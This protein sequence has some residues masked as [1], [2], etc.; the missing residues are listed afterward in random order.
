M[1]LAPTREQSLIFSLFSGMLCDLVRWGS[2]TVYKGQKE[3]TIEYFAVKSIDKSLRSK[4]LTKVS[5]LLPCVNHGSDDRASRSSVS[6][7]VGCLNFAPGL[8]VAF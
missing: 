3:K 7:D 1:D 6:L 5:A 2:K 8:D 4:V